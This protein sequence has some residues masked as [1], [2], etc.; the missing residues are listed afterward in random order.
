MTVDRHR[1]LASFDEEPYRFRGS[2][3]PSPAKALSVGVG[4]R[5]TDCA[6]AYLVEGG[7]DGRA[8]ELGNSGIT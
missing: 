6:P 7:R 4:G 3:E 8:V 1:N 2:L 5:E